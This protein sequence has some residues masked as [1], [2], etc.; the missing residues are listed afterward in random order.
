MF[1]SNLSKISFLLVFFFSFFFVLKF[2]NYNNSKL[3]YIPSDT[4][5]IAS[6]NLSKISDT[7]DYF[8]FIKSEK[9]DNL[10]NHLKNKNIP[11]KI[12]DIIKDP[13]VIGLDYKKNIYFSSSLYSENNN[14]IYSN[15]SLN[16]ILPI[17]D[18]KLISKNINQYVDFI[19][20]KEIDIFD[21]EINGF[22]YFLFKNRFNEK[23]DLVMLSYNED[24]VLLSVAPLNP[25]ISLDLKKQLSNLENFNL[26]NEQKALNLKTKQISLWVDLNKLSVN[27]SKYLFEDYTFINWC[28][29]DIL[30]SIN[31]IEDEIKFELHSFLKFN[32]YLKKIYPI[33]NLLN[34]NMLYRFKTTFDFDRIIETKKIFLDN[35]SIEKIELNHYFY[36]D[37]YLLIIKD[38]F[39][40][41]DKN[42]KNYIFSKLLEFIALL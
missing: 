25:L 23:R 13:S 8:D 33:I 10:L 41:D 15:L 1:I 32:F 27:Q 7:N 28:F 26:I 39:F 5:L 11:K 20:D 18:L 31:S 29:S 2:Q 22:K 4:F 21:G 30:L 34:S 40:I 17:K 35:Q 16:F 19:P 36:L 3:K 24:V 14:D 6:F 37:K 9:G 12:R 42:L 38:N